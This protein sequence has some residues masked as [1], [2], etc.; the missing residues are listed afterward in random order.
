LSGDGGILAEVIALRQQHGGL[1]LNIAEGTSDPSHGDFPLQCALTAS[2]PGG[3][4]NGDAM[5]AGAGQDGT[6]AV[7][8]WTA[9]QAPVY[10]PNLKK[11]YV[12]WAYRSDIG[13]VA[14]IYFCTVNGQGQ[15][16]G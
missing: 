7:L 16:C 9:G 15:Y 11:V 12:G 14:D 13:Y 1:S 3:C 8:E 6:S 5:W 2:F 4:G 10:S